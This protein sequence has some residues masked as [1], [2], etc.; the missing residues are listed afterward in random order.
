MRIN[1]NISALN[2]YRNLAINNA[3]TAKSLEK[4]S[5]GLRINKASDDA[6][7]LAI[8]E[9]MRSQ[10]R[11]LEMAERNALDGISLIQTAEGA[12]SSSHEILQRMR[13]LAVQAANDS[14]TDT[15]RAEIQKEVNQL[16]SELNRI[17][18]STEFNSASLLDGSRK[19]TFVANGKGF[20]NNASPFVDVNNT[21]MQMAI[22]D[23]DELAVGKHNV[24]V[25]RTYAG[26]ADPDPIVPAENSSIFAGGRIEPTTAVEADDWTLTFQEGKDA[27]I[28]N[29]ESNST[30]VAVKVAN[31]GTNLSAGTHTVQVS[32]QEVGAAFPGGAP[33]YTVPK[34]E[35]AQVSSNSLNGSFTFRDGVINYDTT[36]NKIG[37]PAVKLGDTI[38]LKYDGKAFTVSGGPI[39][40]ELYTPGTEF[41]HHGLKFTMEATDFASG[42]EISF[43][44]PGDKGTIATEPKPG[45][46]GSFTFDPAEPFTVNTEVGSGSWTIEK[47]ASGY[48]VSFDGSD[49]D[50]NPSK[51]TEIVA[52]NA[53]YNEH[54]LEFQLVSSDMSD[55]DKITF[56]TTTANK[57]YD[58][59]I[60]VDGTKHSV[61]EVMGAGTAGSISSSYAYAGL[62]QFEG[63]S[64]DITNLTEGT[65][66]FTVDP[67]VADKFSLAS[68]SGK[69]G[70]VEVG[71]LFDE[72]GLQFVVE[73]TAALSN[74]Q[75]IT[76]S[77]VDP[78]DGYSY[79]VSIDGKDPMEVAVNQPEDKPA[80]V[81]AF[82]E[83]PG[84][85]LNAF[86]LKEGSF[87]FE[88]VE[89]GSGRD[90]SLSFQIGANSGQAVT[91]EVNDM[92]AAALEITAAK[93][94]E[95]VIT[96]ASGKEQKVWYTSNPTVSNGVSSENTEFAVDVSTHEKAQA[97]ISVFS[98][99]IQKVSSERAR[100]GA[101]Q[102]RLEHTVDNL[103]IM[104]ENVTSSESRIRD[105]DMAKEM[106]TFTKNNILNQAAQAMLSQANQMPQGVLQL[107]K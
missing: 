76:F 60:D 80:Q 37:L 39:T 48:Q 75:A 45:F 5:S 44:I 57:M 64:I 26:T 103:K 62:A 33:N 49:K 18:N 56:D 25:S 7:G 29:V 69:T 88:I 77:T 35:D 53:P 42:E 97:A 95:N 71:K 24:T 106:S 107:L 16:T 8:S 34:A 15:D 28:T 40:S 32:A 101:I 73:N 47:V 63:L 81:L 89:T 74:G 66:N 105:L 93:A 92:R 9:K 59:T 12:L 14:Y 98:N 20:A 68:G 86:D 87:S 94:G 52:E 13:E 78:V 58:F 22:T 6:A 85:Q 10:I 36:S 90:G 41:N 82:E 55:G 79:S 102:N 51:F 3:N 2:A 23:G 50:G 4:L 84:L 72:Y 46:S 104:T 27:A 19:N 11:G 38:T 70:N 43:T 96:L 91:L 67:A 100:L 99:A 83:I 65:F 31:G 21:G 54:G 61:P 17:G 1:H 30:G